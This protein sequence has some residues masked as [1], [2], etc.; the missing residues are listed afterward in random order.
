MFKECL[1]RVGS[2][3]SPVVP[4]ESACAVPGLTS[5]G[6]FHH[7]SGQ[8]LLPWPLFAVPTW[9]CPSGTCS[10][11]RV[12]CQGSAFHWGSW[13]LHEALEVLM[14]RVVGWDGPDSPQ[15]KGQ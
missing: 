11:S 5:P 3:P 4:Y 8:V 9:P 6:T 12:L 2:S 14:D 13:E 7:P 15:G 1:G 10:S